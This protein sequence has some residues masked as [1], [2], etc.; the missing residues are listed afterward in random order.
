MDMSRFITIKTIKEK[1]IWAGDIADPWHQDLQHGTNY[2]I[3][4]RKSTPKALKLK[5]ISN[6][7][8]AQLI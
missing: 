4:G 2:W 3:L 1:P 7:I 5:A 8:V 6:D